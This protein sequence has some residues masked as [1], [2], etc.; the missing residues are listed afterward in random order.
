MLI[1]SDSGLLSSPFPLLNAWACL[2]HTQLKKTQE[3]MEDVRDAL[4]LLD[5]EEGGAGWNSQVEHQ[6]P[7]CTDSP[8]NT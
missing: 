6:P 4:D 2:F 1:L 5:A 8:R 3:L 7:T